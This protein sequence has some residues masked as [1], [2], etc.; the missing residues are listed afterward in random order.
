MPNVGKSTIFNALVKAKKAAAENYPFCTIDP[1]VGVVEVPDPRLD[2]IAEL[3]KSEKIT[4]AAI[5]FV[6][7]AGLVAGAHKGEGLGNQFLSHIREVDAIALVLRYFLDPN[8]IHVAGKIDPEEDY[9]I[10]L[11]ELIMADLQTLSKKIAAEEGL[12]KSGDKES[13][14]KLEIYKKIEA[15][16]NQEKP[17]KEVVDALDKPERDL[18]RDLQLLTA[19]PIIPVANISD[20]MIGKEILLFGKPIIAIS[21]KTETELAELSGDE[22]KEFIASIGLTESG[23][24]KLIREGYKILGLITFLTGGPKEARAWTVRAGAKAPEAAGKI[25]TDFEKKF[26]A[27][28]VI[29]YDDFVKCGNWVKARE[30]GLVRLEGKEYIFRDGDVVIFRHG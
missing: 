19:K 23:F 24:D 21:A 26:I 22:Q 2:K 7:I 5:Q 16:L 12:T 9:K 18:I 20:D 29:A 25:H 1:N 11:I 3:E 28:D 10:I 4:P 14:K 15:A 17:A 13:A 27:A 6:D 8:V 30:V